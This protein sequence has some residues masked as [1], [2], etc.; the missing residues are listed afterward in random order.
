MS[1]K[2]LDKMSWSDYV[3]VMLDQLGM[4]SNKDFKEWLLTKGVYNTRYFDANMYRYCYQVHEKLKTDRDHVTVIVGKEGKGKSTLGINIAGMVSDNFSIK[5]I[6]YEPED[7]VAQLRSDIPKGSTLQMD[8]GA[9]FL[10]S[11]DAMGNDSRTIVRLLTIIRQMNLHIIICVPNFWII[12]KYVREH[13]VDAVF[14]VTERGSY[15][16]IISE[17]VPFISNVER[18][19]KDLQY[20]LRKIPTKFWWRGSYVKELVSLNDVNME[21]YNQLKIDA[22]NKHLD[23]INKEYSEDTE[24]DYIKASDFR[25]KI[26]ISESGLH[27]AIKRGDYDARKIGDRWYIHKDELLGV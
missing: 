8:E 26:G 19:V 15:T 18:N 7:F 25:K 27:R 1:D 21:T 9:L 14:H 11:R 5:H 10:F 4:S 16:G 6:C 13:R 24:F 22:R 23:K 2:V 3:N 17:G 20:K 12:D